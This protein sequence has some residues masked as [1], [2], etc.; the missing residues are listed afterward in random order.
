M[1]LRLTRNQLAT[2]L[3]D[4]EQ[5]RQ[6][7]TLFSVAANS[8]SLTELESVMVMAAQSQAS[9]DSAMAYSIRS[10]QESALRSL[11]ADQKASLALSIL[12]A[13]PERITTAKGQF[14]YG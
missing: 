10:S 12:G 8:A 9:A 3:K 2:F 4:H 11:G 7:E 1:N 14:I 13:M 5:I 6:F